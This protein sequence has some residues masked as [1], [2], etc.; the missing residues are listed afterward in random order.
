MTRARRRVPAARVFAALAFLAVAGT[1]VAA[2]VDFLRRHEPGIA[3]RRYWVPQV[4]QIWAPGLG[5]SALLAAVAFALHRRGR[6]D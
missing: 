2:Q 4:T 6:A 3:P 5:V 1:Y